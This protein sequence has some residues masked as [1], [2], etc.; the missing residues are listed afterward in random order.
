MYG[1]II[2]SPVERLSP[3]R[4]LPL[5]LSS[6]ESLSRVESLQYS[7][8]LWKC[9]PVPLR[10]RTYYVGRSDCEIGISFSSSLAELGT[11]FMTESR[12]G[13]S[14]S[15]GGRFVISAH[16]NTRILEKVLV[17][18]PVYHIRHYYDVAGTR[19]RNG[20]ILVGVED[21]AVGVGAH[22]LCMRN[23]VREVE[24]DVKSSGK[25][26]GSY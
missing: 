20:Y 17:C 18:R 19:T 10:P 13:L 16:A 4:P 26:G 24:R 7:T 21:R 22:A 3:P 6:E 11:R 25:K 14:V 23:G 12:M 8:G 2:F 9:P 1:I 15:V 5:N